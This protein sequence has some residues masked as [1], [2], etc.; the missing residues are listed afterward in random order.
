MDR[1][2]ILVV[3]DEKIVAMDVSG[4]LAA[5]GYEVAGIVSTGEEAI[6][7]ANSEHVDLVVMDIRLKG[8][9]DGLQ[10]AEELRLSDIPVVYLTAYAD[11]STL[12]RAKLDNSMGYILKPFE[13]RELHT[14]VE[15]ALYRHRMERRLLI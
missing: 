9:V 13:D 3:E 10:A 11:E 4:S 6:R 14:I 5:Q 2:R 8:E 12:E 7:I 1:A 15:M